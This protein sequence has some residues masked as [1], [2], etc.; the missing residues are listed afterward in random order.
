MAAPPFLE[1]FFKFAWSIFLDKMKQKNILHPTT[2][3]KISQGL[4]KC[5]GQ[6]KLIS[7]NLAGF[8]VTIL[9]VLLAYLPDCEQPYV[10]LGLF[11]CLAFSLSFTVGG[12][13]TSML[14]IAPLYTGVLSSATMLAGISGRVTTPILVSYFN[15]TVR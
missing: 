1:L 11:I 7:K 5:N 15:K 12:F 6:N 10:T 4:C 2:A 9:F 3:C 14:S 8:F 13:F